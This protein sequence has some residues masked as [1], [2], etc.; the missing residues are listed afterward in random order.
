[1]PHLLNVIFY[2]FPCLAVA[3]PFASW[4]DV[5]AECG[6]VGDGQ[7]DDTIAIQKGLDLIRPEDS[8]RKILHFPAG[9]YR[10]TGT[11]Q[12]VREKHR[13]CQGIGL[14]GEGA[15][16][17]VIMYEGR[18][19]EPMVRWGAWYSTIRSL[20]FQSRE[21]GSGRR[22]AEGE[23]KG[24]TENSKAKDISSTISK[25]LS[26]TG[27]AKPASGI[28]F[29][30]KFATMNE[31]ADCRFT[32]LPVGILG[33]ERTM[34]GQAETCVR[35]CRFEGCG[36]GILLQNWNSLDWWVW[37]SRFTD[38]DTALSNEPG[39]GNFN[40]YR[41]LFLSSRRADVRVGN[42]LG[43]FSLVENESRGSRKFFET[44]SGH[45]A[46]GIFTFHGNRVV[47]TGQEPAID[48][49]NCGPVLSLDN[50]FVATGP[51]RAQA[52]RFTSANRIDP[53]G[54]AMLMGDRATN[55]NLFTAD[56]GY[57]VRVVEDVE[58]GRGRRKR[59]QIENGR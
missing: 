22:E 38:C 32:G 28:L 26:T 48:M 13:E 2:L 52:F 49:G 30:P 36:T 14:Q 19:N 54:N 41:C 33:G 51:E 29:G 3:A 10:I 5:K 50:E 23:Q 35:R 21:V 59:T 44:R 20:G 46:G 40:A 47:W 24:E 17:S 16:K 15:D 34:A 4:I 8:Q 9:T 37:D 42:V 12:A 39:C 56:Q 6:A 53:T 31:V 57:C 45:T 55:A 43:A 11:I 1:M 18:G 25:L 7:A 58:G 27:P